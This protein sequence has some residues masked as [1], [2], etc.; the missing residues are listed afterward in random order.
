MAALL[1]NFSSLIA[2]SVIDVSNILAVQAYKAIIPTDQNTPAFA[3]AVNIE[4]TGPA[5]VFMSTFNLE[6]I[7][8]NDEGGL[9]TAISAGT[10]SGGSVGA[11]GSVVGGSATPAVGSEDG[12]KNFAKGIGSPGNAI[13]VMILGSIFI[14]V[15][16]F[17]FF[18][19]ALLLIIRFAVLVMVIVLAPVAFA[20]MAFPSTKKLL[21]Q[22]WDA[23]LNQAFFAPLYLFFLWITAM[24]ATSP[25]F[26][27]I[28]ASGFYDTITSK[29]NFQFGPIFAFALIICLLVWSLIQAKSLASKGGGV[30]SDL[31]GK[32]VGLAGG[33]TFGLAGGVGRKFV[34]G[35]AERLADSS[36]MRRLESSPL[37]RAFGATQ[38]RQGLQ[39]VAKSSFDVR[40]TGI[41]KSLGAGAA[42][43]KGGYSQSLK[44]KQ[45]HEQ[46][47]YGHA[48]GKSFAEQQKL[49]PAE[50]GLAEKIGA[51]KIAEEEVSKARAAYNAVA[52]PANLARLNTARRN[53]VRSKADKTAMADVVKQLKAPIEEREKNF[54]KG[55]EKAGVG[56]ALAGTRR[57]KKM[58][59][60]AVR[61]NKGKS[62][63][64]LALEEIK[65]ATKAATPPP[66][67]GTP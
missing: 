18:A 11:G 21:S 13:A 27:G 66:A 54:L 47:A 45:K 15:A 9:G 5:N 55:L 19:G 16:S 2:K 50:A 65:K 41:G 67:P 52:S 56:S 60:L 20:S 61:K 62:D 1:I 14:L 64:D 17:V 3:G 6:S 22:W 4:N 40:G 30:V 26:K 24:I 63:L 28:I 8:P 42:G 34:G 32:A 58:A 7:F 23:L 38:L 25:S 46:E 53:V 48:S 29:D 37:A 43:G 33:A 49:Q 35:S 12:A 39:G 44:D 51:V 10:G 57:A 36:F 59:A 31:A